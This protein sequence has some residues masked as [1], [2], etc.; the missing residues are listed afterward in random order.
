VSRRWRPVIWLMVAAG[1]LGALGALVTPHRIID[2][3]SDM[4]S[5]AH[6]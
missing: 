5:H 1:A 6:T 3:C 4:L 2:I